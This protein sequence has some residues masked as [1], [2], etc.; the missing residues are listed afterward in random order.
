MTT[1]PGTGSSSV[2]CETPGGESTSIA[3]GAVFG[4]T[5]QIGLV[6]PG[7]QTPNVNWP[8]VAVNARAWSGLKPS[9]PVSTTVNVQPGPGVPKLAAFPAGT[10]CPQGLASEAH[11]Y[12][13]RARLPA[14]VNAAA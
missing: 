4:L 2:D 12:G 10:A 13:G 5:A 6:P 7:A 1:G 8:G 9:W 3:F 14:A 11:G